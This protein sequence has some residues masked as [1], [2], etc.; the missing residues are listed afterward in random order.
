MRERLVGL[1]P[2]SRRTTKQQRLWGRGGDVPSMYMIGHL[3]VDFVQ[4]RRGAGH[5]KSYGGNALHSALGA[6]PARGAAQA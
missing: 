6:N 4:H 2:M 3:T 5:Q 1:T